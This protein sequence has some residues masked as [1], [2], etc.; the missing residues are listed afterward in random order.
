M[1]RS[2]AGRRPSSR[3]L[4]RL[5]TSRVDYPN[6]V[7]PVPASGR[8][9]PPAQQDPPDQRVPGKTH[10]DAT[11][12]TRAN[13]RAA[14]ARPARKRS[15][16]T[17]RGPQRGSPRQDS[18][19][20]TV[21]PIVDASSDAAS[22]PVSHSVGESVRSS[23][24]VSAQREQVTSDELARLR[25]QVMDLSS[26]LAQAGV[27]LPSSVSGGTVDSVGPDTPPAAHRAGSGATSETSS[28]RGTRVNA[29]VTSPV[30]G[31]RIRGQL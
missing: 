7:P 3:A 16:V 1:R 2:T 25:R 22:P 15:P 17:A 14:S 19:A 29:H 5:V 10:A 23:V 11:G 4:A 27:P 9:V 6:L 30:P 13:V 8:G 24:V 18:P 21:A 20:S 28:A 12:H 31:P 26:A